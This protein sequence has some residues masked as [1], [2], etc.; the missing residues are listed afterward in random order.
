MIHDIPYLIDAFCSK[1]ARRCSKKVAL[2]E[3]KSYIVMY[4]EDSNVWLSNIA[5]LRRLL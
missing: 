1:I 2:L 3:I 5:R 4:S